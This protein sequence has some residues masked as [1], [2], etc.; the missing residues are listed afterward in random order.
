M[1]ET[2]DIF[3]YNYY[4]YISSI[5]IYS[6]VKTYL[7]DPSRQKVEKIFDLVL[8]FL[9]GIFCLSFAIKFVIIL[10]YFFVIQSIPALIRFMANLCKLK[11]DINFSSSCNNAFSY[12]KKVMK[13]ISTFNFYLYEN[14]PVGFAMILSFLLFIFSTFTFYLFNQ[15]QLM[16]REKNEG[17]MRLFYLHFESI[18]LIQLLCSSFYACRNMTLSTISAIVLFILLNVI[19][20]LGYLVKEKVENVVGIYENNEPQ[21][22][23]NAIFNLVFLL[24]NGKCFFNAI[25]FNQNSKKKNILIL[26]LFIYS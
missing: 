14:I 19:L 17:Y 15:K 7:I 26:I 13:R 16:L 1:S 6:H 8:A 24:L 2:R 25:F 10:L 12:L 21:I 4:D 11:C 23:M 5:Y 3:L 22:I 9:S 20:Y 18:L